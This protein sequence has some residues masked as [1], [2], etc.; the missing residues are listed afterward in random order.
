MRTHFLE[1][2]P[3]MSLETWDIAEG[4]LAGGQ[5]EGGAHW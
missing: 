5:E 2:S 3:F 4:S 1:R